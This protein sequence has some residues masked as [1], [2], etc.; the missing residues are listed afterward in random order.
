MECEGTREGS[1]VVTSGLFFFSDTVPVRIREQKFSKVS[2][3]E[4]LLCKV[5]IQSTFE[6]LF[7]ARTWRQFWRERGQRL[8]RAATQCISMRSITGRQNCA[9]EEAVT[10]QKVSKRQSPRLLS[11]KR[12]LI[13]IKRAQ[14]Y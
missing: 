1:Q 11:L 2:A 12:D 6:N 10:W 5:S 7:F 9:G 14:R 4:Y 8:R 13:S 3:K